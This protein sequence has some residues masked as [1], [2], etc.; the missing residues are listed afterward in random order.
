RDKEQ[1]G[2]FDLPVNPTPGTDPYFIKSATYQIYQM[3]HHKGIAGGYISRTYK[4]HPLFPQLMADRL[5][6]DQDHLFLNGQLARYDIAQAELARYGY[7]YVVWHKAQENAN[8][9]G[10]MAAAAFIGAVFGQQAPLIDDD[11]I[12]VYQVRQP[13]ITTAIAFGANWRYP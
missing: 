4:E 6:Q 9:A 1:Y 11:L 5:E 12:R 8:I 13:P 3:T 10:D 2:I 7:R